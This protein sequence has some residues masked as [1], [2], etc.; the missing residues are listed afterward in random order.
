[1]PAGK[2]LV[3]DRIADAMFQQLLLRPDEY[4]VIATPN[5]NGDY[6]SDAC[7]AQVGGSAS[8]P[9]PTSATTYAVFEATHGTAP[10]Y[11]GKDMVN[12]G[13]LLLSAVMMLEHLGWESPTTLSARC[14]AAPRSPPASSPRTSSRRSR[15]RKVG[16]LSKHFLTVRAGAN[17]PGANCFFPLRS[18][19]SAISIT[20]EMTE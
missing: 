7:A 4:D 11:A 20:T 5:L 17:R 2:I 10:K 12:P 18:D 6:L 14:R 19:R 15:R 16:R 8:R 3:N 1:M 13:S 9:A